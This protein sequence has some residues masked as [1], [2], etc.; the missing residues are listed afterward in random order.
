MC[1]RDRSGPLYGLAN[2]AMLKVKEMS[3]SH[4]EAYH[5]LEFRHGPMSMVD[6]HTLVVGLV[7]DTACE[8]EIRLLQEME[9]LGART[10]V[11]VEEVSRLGKW[12]PSY[13]AELRSGLGEW[14]RTPL[15]LPILQRLAYHRAVT[16]GLDPDHPRHLQAVVDL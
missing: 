11:V 2:E 7:S 5:F 14:E 10:F 12:R 6:G 16:K 1:I 15:Y 4:A 9:G 8:H 3:L 13:V